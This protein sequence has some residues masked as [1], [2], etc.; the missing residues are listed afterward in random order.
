VAVLGVWLWLSEAKPRPAGLLG[1]AV[2]GGFCY[3]Q[4]AGAG[5]ACKARLGGL[6]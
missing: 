4:P 1:G 5:W 2:R 6:K 3:A